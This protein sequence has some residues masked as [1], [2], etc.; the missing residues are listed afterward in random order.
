M[1]QDNWTREQTI[2]ALNLYCKIPFN[3]VASKH[4]DIIEVAKIIGRSPNAVKMKI[5]N[6]GSFDPELKRRGIVGLAIQVILIRKF[7]LSLIAIGMG[8]PMKAKSYLQSSPTRQLKRFLK[9]KQRTC[10]LGKSERQ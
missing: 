8:L 3:R 4:P 9:L 10:L 1:A 7:G 5:G 2:V 6:F